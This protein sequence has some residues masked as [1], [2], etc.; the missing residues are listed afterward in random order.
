MRGG[1]RNHR[2]KAFQSGAAAASIGAMRMPGETPM[3]IK[4]MVK[5][6]DAAFGAVA[7]L[8]LGFMVPAASAMEPRAQDPSVGMTDRV[9]PRAMPLPAPVGH[10]QPRAADVPAGLAKNMSDEEHE[11]RERA[12]S[13]RLQICRGC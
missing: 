4:R 12:L 11:R 3:S 13:R 8:A 5:T 7:L 10:R 6:R 2:R 1:Y 9:Q